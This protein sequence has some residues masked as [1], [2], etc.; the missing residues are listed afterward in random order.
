M[1]MVG[2]TNIKKWTLHIVYGLLFYEHFIN[3]LINFVNAKKKVVDMFPGT[4]TSIMTSQAM[5]SAVRY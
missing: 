2:E 5:L 4:Q 3:V 1:K